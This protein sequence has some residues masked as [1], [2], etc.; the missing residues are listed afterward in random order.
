MEPV[1]VAVGSNLGDRLSYIQKAGVFLSNLS[2]KTAI[3]SSIWE[4]EPVGDAKYTFLNSVAR[5]FTSV[6]PRELL[7]RFKDF[8]Q[9]CGRE[10]NPKRWGPRV[11]DLDLIGYGDLVIQQEDLI[12]PH[13]EYRKRLFVLL[14]LQEVDDEWR[15][16]VTGI[17]IEKLT[18]EAPRMQ[19]NKTEYDW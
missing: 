6:E 8:E 13:P 11:I 3:K 19:I 5:I 12:I 15:D 14:P 9:T 16:P 10:K 2:D 17:H 1:I 4:S 7:G 18:E